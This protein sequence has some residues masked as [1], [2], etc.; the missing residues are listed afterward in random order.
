MHCRNCPV[1]E[2]AAAVIL[3]RRRPPG[4]QRLASMATAERSPRA[5]RKSSA[6]IFRLHSEWLALPTQ[7]FQE[8]S[9]LKAVHTLPHRSQGIVRGIVNVRGELLVCV[10]LDRLISLSPRKRSPA[11]PHPRERL[12]V[13]QIGQEKVCFPADEVH[14]IHHFVLD[15]LQ[16]PPA[17]VLTD[18][19]CFT[20]GILPWNNRNVGFLDYQALASAIDDCLS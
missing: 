1:H 19:T 13:L 15:Q 6:M 16:R 8:V 20:H 4:L 7:A 18:S 9:E 10:A 3:A 11:G 5:A 2:Q 17:T 12:L 14:G